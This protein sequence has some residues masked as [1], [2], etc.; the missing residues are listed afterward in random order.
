M[1]YRGQT[2]KQLQC[3]C[4]SGGSGSVWGTNLYTDDSNICRAAVHAGVMTT[5]GGTVTI[6]VQPAQNTF[7]G[8]TRNGVT[9]S[10]YGY[11]G[12]SYRFI[13][14]QIPQPQPAPLCSTFN[15]M[16]YRGQTGRAIRCGCPSVSLGASFWGTDLYT[17]DS[18]VCV[19]AVHAG[20]IPASGGNVTV[21]IQPGQS[22]YTSTHRYGVTSSSYGYWEGS[23]SLSP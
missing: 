14:P 4:S 10:S 17:D 18:D 7:I 12:G 16:S 1:E 13:G 20:A 9:T 15:M 11:W 5:S 6:E 22:S 21:T 8:T 23:I 3:T 19:A 2:G